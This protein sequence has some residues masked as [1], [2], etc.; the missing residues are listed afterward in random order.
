MSSRP[1]R[2]LVP[3]CLL[4]FLGFIVQPNAQAAELNNGTIS[5]QLGVDSAGV[6]SIRDASWVETGAQI[7]SDQELEDGLNAWVPRALIPA[8]GLKIKGD[9]W[10]ISD[11]AV[12]TR[13]EA[14]GKLAGGVRITWVVELANSGSILR[15]HVRLKNSALMSQAIDWFPVWAASWSAERASS[16]VRWW[17]S[18]EFTPV[19]ERLDDDEKVRMGSEL[20]SSDDAADG[21]NPFWVVFGEQGRIYFGVEWCGG[22]GSKLKGM[23]HGLKFN[24]WLPAEDTQLTL[25]SG[26]A[27]DGPALLVVPT[28]CSDDASARRDWMSQR[29][30]LATNL[31]GGGAPQFP[32]TYNHWYAAKLTFDPDFLNRQIAAMTPYDFDFFIVDAG[33]YDEAGS[34]QPDRAKFAAGQLEELLSSIRS[35]GT[36]IGIWSAPQFVSA[37]GSRLPADAESPPLFSD[38]LNAYLLDLAD[39][40]FAS[41]LNKHVSGL[42]SRFQADWWKY[43]QQFFTAQSRAGAMRNVLA[44]QSALLS[45]RAQNPDMVIENCQSGGRMLNEFTLQVTQT[46]WLRDGKDNG[47]DHARQNIE[48][49]LGALEFVFPWTAYRFTN[50]LDRMDQSDD[51]TT[52][53]YCRSAMAGIWGISADLAGISERQRAVVLAEIANYKRLNSLKSQCLYSLEQPADGADTAGVT[54]FDPYRKKAAAV[55]YRWDKAGEFDKQVALKNLKPSSWYDVTDVDTGITTRVRGRD[56]LKGGVQVHFSAERMSAIVFIESRKY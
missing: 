53:M 44:F 15:L 46:S 9:P 10:V 3:C 37:D 18:L 52:R 31:Y 6:P 23:E 39:S 19:E 30:E 26:E 14:T 11:G 56:L 4:L 55:I 33:W 50:N 16:Q 1:M 41:R 40:S 43:D 12:F 32:L 17:R 34:W 49:A 5:L 36:K 22:W 2:T 25:K 45:V 29:K 13:A 42:R 54:Y 28:R 27:V 48:V 35:S 47:L 21:V 38:F 7:F 8:S 24:V 51:E 20:H